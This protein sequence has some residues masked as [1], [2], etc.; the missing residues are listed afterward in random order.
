MTKKKAK[1]GR[2]R[3]PEQ[4]KLSYQAKTTLD[5]ET[6][7]ALNTEIAEGKLGE[8][9]IVR[10]AIRIMLKDRGYLA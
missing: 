6:R 7:E 9:E 1:M 5:K 2:P 3:K 10:E 8:A 4:E